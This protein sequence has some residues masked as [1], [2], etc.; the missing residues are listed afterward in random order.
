MAAAADMSELFA[1]L[2]NGLLC[3]LNRETLFIQAWGKGLRVRATMANS[4]RDDA[5]SALLPQ[6]TPAA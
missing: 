1:T 6:E 5:L 2:P 4:F 3:R